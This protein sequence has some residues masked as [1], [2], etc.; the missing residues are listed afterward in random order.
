MKKYIPVKE[1]QHGFTHIKMEVFYTLGGYSYFSSHQTPRGY[2]LSAL[3]VKREAHNYNGQTVMTES[4]IALS[5]ALS[6]AKSLLKPVARKSD[7][8]EKEAEALAAA[9]LA[10]LLNHVLAASGLELETPDAARLAS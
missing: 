2:Y 7:K 8:A 5:R 1:N 6:G 4:Y 3:P 9:E 10:P